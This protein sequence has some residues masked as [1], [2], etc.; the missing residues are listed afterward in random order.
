MHKPNTHKQSYTMPSQRRTSDFKFTR[1]TARFAPLHPVG[2]KGIKNNEDKIKSS[3]K[4]AKIK[5]SHVAG[6]FQ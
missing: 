3:Q 6:R 1:Q 2:N 4:E 5:D